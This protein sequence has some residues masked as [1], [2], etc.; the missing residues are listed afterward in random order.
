LTNLQHLRMSMLKTCP[1][2]P[3]LRIQK[4]CWK[5]PWCSLWKPA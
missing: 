4:T 3:W 5:W 2:W 1:K